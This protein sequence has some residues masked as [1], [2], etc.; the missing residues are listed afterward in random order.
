MGAGSSCPV[1]AWLDRTEDTISLGL[2]ELDGRFNLASRNFDKAAENLGRAA[3]V[4]LSGEFLH[5]AVESEGQAVFAAAKAGQ[6][7]LDWQARDRRALDSEGQP[8]ERSR[9]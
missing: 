1:D 8:T 2:R 6:L 3:P 5:Q 7:P 9:I 4:F